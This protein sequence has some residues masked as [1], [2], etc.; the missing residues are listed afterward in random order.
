MAYSFTNWPQTIAN[1][2]TKPEFQNAHIV[3][4]V[5]EHGGEYDVDSG[6]TTGGTEAELLYDGQARI[7]GIRQSAESQ[8]E[9]NPTSLK[10]VRVQVNN[11]TLGRVPNNAKAYF[12]DGGRNVQLLDY[13]FNVNSD[14]NSSQVAAYTFEMTVD[15]DAVD[16]D[17][18]VFP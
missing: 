9:S 10:G 8:Q 2:S 13:I 3:L 15:L 14:F 17:K 1:I 4:Y 18:P 12:T 16:D 5:P 11:R 6:E 7:V